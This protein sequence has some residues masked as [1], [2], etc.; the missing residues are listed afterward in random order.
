[1]PPA[2]FAEAIRDL[3]VDISHL[4][5]TRSMFCVVQEASASPL[6]LFDR[7]QNWL[8]LNY[9]ITCSIALRRQSDDGEDAIPLTKFLAAL[10]KSPQVVTR[11]SFKSLYPPESDDLADSIF[12]ELVGKGNELTKT[13]VGDDKTAF[14]K[15]VEP[16]RDFALQRIVHLLNVR[17]RLI[18]S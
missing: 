15:K 13:I 9:M 4:A 12:N 1:M 14:R 6:S 10:V 3:L 8:L 2:N 18:C 16:I 7:F 11:A 17:L 5:F